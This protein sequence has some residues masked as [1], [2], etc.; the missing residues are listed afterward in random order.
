MTPAPREHHLLA[1]KRRL[2]LFSSPEALAQLGVA[3]EDAALLAEVVPE[4][5]GSRRSAAS[6]PGASAG[7]GCSSPARR[8]AA[9]PCT[10]A[11][12]SRGASSTRSRAI[13]DFLAQ[14]RVE[15]GEVE[16]E[17]ERG[18]ARDEVRRARLR[19]PRRGPAARRARLPGTG[20]QPAQ[21]GRRLL[22]DLRARAASRPRASPRREPA[23]I[24]LGAR[25]SAPRS[26]G[27][28]FLYGTAAALVFNVVHRP[29]LG[30]AAFAYAAGSSRARRRDR[31]AI[32]GRVGA[33]DARAHVGMGVAS[34]HRPAVAS[35]GGGRALACCASRA[36][37]SAASGAEPC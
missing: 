8:S 7:S 30:R 23:A 21:R 5:R 19:L 15:P 22:G 12:R 20:H 34:L 13:A 4:T 32:R 16:V 37:A 9:A 11:T 31:E 28:T 3:A 35:L 29:A 36:S 14:R 27:T 10:A 24:R 26:S 17:T 1:N 6:A 25:R 33:V 18:R 2:A